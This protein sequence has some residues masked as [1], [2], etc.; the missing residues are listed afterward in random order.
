MTQTSFELF[1]KSLSLK[2][3]LLDLLTPLSETRTKSSLKNEKPT[4]SK[5]LVDL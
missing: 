3:V 2:S 5:S 1:D 4:T